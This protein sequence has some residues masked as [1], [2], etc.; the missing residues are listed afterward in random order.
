MLKINCRDYS[1]A[2]IMTNKNPEVPQEE[3]GVEQLLDTYLYH[4]PDKLSYG[5]C[6]RSRV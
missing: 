5:E 4:L 3:S 6:A 2:V 1:T